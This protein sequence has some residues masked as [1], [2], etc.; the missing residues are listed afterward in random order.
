MVK[1]KHQVYFLTGNYYH[2]RQ[3]ISNIKKQLGVFDMH[4]FDESDPFDLVEYKIM[5]YSCF[6]EQRLIILN[7][8]PIYKKRTNRRSKKKD[9]DEE[10]KVTAADRAALLKE[11]KDM[12]PNIPDDCVVIF[13]NVKIMSKPF[14]THVEEIGERCK[15]D[16]NVNFGE[17][18]GHIFKYCEEKGKSIKEE[19]VEM[20]INSFGNVKEVNLDNI[21]VL[22]DRLFQYVGNKKRVTHNDIMT[23]CSHSPEFI[24]W[25]LYNNL[26]DRNLCR[27][28][29]LIEDFLSLYREDYKIRVEIGKLLAGMMW[30]YKLMLMTRG[31][32]DEGLREKEIKSK[33][34]KLIKPDKDGPAGKLKAKTKEKKDIPVYSEKA[35]E[36]TIWKFQNKRSG[37]ST[38]SR[39]ELLFINF[40]VSSIWAKVR[41]S[42]YGTEAQMLLRLV[43]FVICGKISKAS[44]LRPFL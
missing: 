31:C 5:E 16:L 24:I 28:L 9:K 43:V 17:S 3:K 40:F 12:L 7:E 42:H 36:V 38:Y 10:D 4:I 34:S 41:K 29:P 1:T 33:I 23:A 25:D 8:L 30:K 15:Y 22:L 2:R 14:L 13:N 37:L 19:D 6:G 20:I 35:I 21:H 39:E 11:F 44:Q 32:L 18:K 27:S 26:D